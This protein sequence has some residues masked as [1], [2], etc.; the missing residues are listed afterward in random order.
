MRLI[1]LDNAARHA[2]SR[3]RVTSSADVTDPWIGVDDDGLGIA[4][5]ARA[6]VLATGARIKAA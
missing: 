6:N 2:P 3:V 4:P 1:L 5:A